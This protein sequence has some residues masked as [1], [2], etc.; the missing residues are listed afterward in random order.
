VLLDEKFHETLKYYRILKNGSVACLTKY[1]EKVMYSPF[2][3]TAELYIF[4][5]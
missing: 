2:L 5:V 4:V 3:I 1:N